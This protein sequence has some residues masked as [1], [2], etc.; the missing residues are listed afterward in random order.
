MRDVKGAGHVADQSAEEKKHS[1]V[2]QMESLP[3]ATANGT[4]R[5]KGWVS[6]EILGG[7]IVNGSLS[8]P[9]LLLLPPPASPPN[10]RFPFCHLKPTEA[11]G[12]QFP[13]SSTAP[14]G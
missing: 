6:L 3:I 7:G 4:S 1:H 5:L 9:L 11:L 10:A 8:S 13:P 12:S 14:G 2:K